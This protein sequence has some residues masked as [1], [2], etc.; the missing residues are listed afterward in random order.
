M[1]RRPRR[2][3]PH[4]LIHQDITGM[5]GFH[6][7]GQK[8]KITPA[9][10]PVPLFPVKRKFRVDIHKAISVCVVTHLIHQPTPGNRVGREMMSNGRP[11]T[12]SAR[13]WLLPAQSLRA[14]HSEQ[15]ENLTDGEP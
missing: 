11:D 10:S 7:I 15:T 6:C 12:L 13:G 1:E 5:Q 3:N 8:Y 4:I 2:S 14:V 9:L